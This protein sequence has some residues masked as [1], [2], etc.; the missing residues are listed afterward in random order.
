MKVLY[1]DNITSISA[2]SAFDD[3]PVSNLQDDHVKKIWKATGNIG[4]VEVAASSADALAVFGTN[5]SAIGVY[6]STGSAVEWEEGYIAWGTNI[7]WFTSTIDWHDD[8]I[9]WETGD[10]AVQWVGDE[11]VLEDTTYDLTAS[12]VGSLWVNLDSYTSNQVIVLNFMALAGSYVYAGVVRMGTTFTMRDPDYGMTEGI[13]DLSLVQEL[14][15]GAVHI[16]ER[17]NIRTFNLKY[18]VDRDDDFYT[19]MYTVMRPRGLKPLA[20]RLSS[21][22]TNWEWIVYARPDGNMPSGTHQY[23]GHSIVNLQLIEVV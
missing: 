17:E 5:A 14:N 12:D 4:Q 16:T 22:L 3:Y 7:D 21:T 8:G 1:D 23:P 11:I 15:N 18:L 9:Q 20:W 19:F 13:K 10:D 6:I 2:N